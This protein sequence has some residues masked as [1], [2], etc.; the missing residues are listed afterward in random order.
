MGHLIDRMAIDHSCL[1]SSLENW[2]T[3]LCIVTK[4]VKTH[5]VRDLKTKTRTWST[6]VGLLSSDARHNRH[7][8][9]KAEGGISL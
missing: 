7:R 5:R 8:P 9:P 6:S 4:A 2:S 3:S 1:L